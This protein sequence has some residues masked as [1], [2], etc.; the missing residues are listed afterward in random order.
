MLVSVL[1]GVSNDS[2]SEKL[3]Y[4][5]ASVHDFNG[6]GSNVRKSPI[7]PYSVPQFPLGLVYGWSMLDTSLLYSFALSGYSSC[8]VCLCLVYM[9]A[10]SDEVGRGE[11]W[12]GVRP[13]YL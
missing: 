12:T 3:C 10:G 11:I 7:E 13:G 6:S 8:G 5:D 9:W 1:N 4:V 2:R